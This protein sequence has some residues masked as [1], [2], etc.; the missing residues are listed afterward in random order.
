MS[1]TTR[2]PTTGQRRSPRT[3]P[4]ALMQNGSVVIALVTAVLVLV[5]IFFVP[6]FA[7]ISNVRAVLIA[8]S[9]TGIAAV[10]LSLIT[11]VGRVFSLSIASTI[12]LTT[13]VFAQTLQFGAIPAL[14]VAIVF[15]TVIGLIQGFIV[16]RLQTDPIITTIAFSAILLGI[17]QI[18]TRGRTVVGEGDTSIFSTNILGLVPFQ[19]VAFLVV[20]VLVFLWHRYS[21]A[22]RRIT[23]IGLN[24]NASKVTGL[25]TWPYVMLAFGVS[26]LATGLT[27]GLLAAQSGQGNL[28]LGG[29]FGFDVVVAAVVGGVGVKGGTGSPLGAAI[30]ALFVGLLGNVLAL[31]GLTYETQLVV[32]GVLVLLAVTLM[33]VSA[34]RTRGR[35]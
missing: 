3:D 4:S 7:T 24:E 1:V 30:G 10:G 16:G 6:N 9:L 15:G 29:T 26:G 13:I 20:T 11:I 28:L 32:K 34:Y 19:V 27:G 14:F 33:G 35:K 18:W 31:M 23:L 2:I 21:V 5:A 22:G 12:A 25:L 8:V 17:G